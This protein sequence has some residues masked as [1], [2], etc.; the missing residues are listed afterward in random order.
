V[1]RGGWGLYYD[2]GT[3]QATRGYSSFPYSTYRSLTNVA[4][5]ATGDNLKTA[6]IS[7]TP[8]FS[9]EFYAF[10][11][12]RM[13]YTHQWNATLEKSAGASGL[14]T[15]S[16][17]GAL[18][19]RLL[20]I[21]SLRNR[22]GLTQLNTAYFASGATVYVVSN[23]SR[24]N[25][26]ALQ[27]QYHRR[28]QRGLQA[29]LSYTWSKSLD[30]LSDENTTAIPLVRAESKLERAR[31]D[32]DIRHTLNFGASW[33]LP[34]ASLTSPLLRK[35]A[36]GWGLDALGRFRTS[37][38][39]NVVS[40]KD[41]LNLGLTTVVRPDLVYG[42]PV[43][44][45]DAHAPGGRRLNAAAFATFAD[46]RQGTLGRNVINGFNG[47]RQVDLGLRRDFPL[48]ERV[49]LQFRAEMFNLTNTPAFGNPTSSLTNSQ[50]G[51]STATLSNT[52]GSFGTGG[53]SSGFA[54]IYQMG[55][56]RST[57]LSLRL[58]F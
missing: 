56:P 4:F 25:Y 42:V 1:V 35:L 9:A 40:S 12:L 7:T 21:E 34:G 50:F 52:L 41:V 13:P 11:N 54:P 16:W 39:V 3:G 6:A 48:A 20:G 29:Q 38:P 53:S 46:A 15:V 5:P 32:F 30:D 23:R 37:S 45:Q 17:V 49:S 58:S 14:L 28:F 27:A 33:D 51:L 10:P 36:R 19:R 55:G 18:G 22:S 57:Q 26:N 8:P 47:I 24:S 31:S 44:I 43:V 2:L